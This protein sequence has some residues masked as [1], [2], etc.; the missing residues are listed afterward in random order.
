VTGVQTCALPISERTPLHVEGPARELFRTL[1]R[2][3][4]RAAHVHPR[5]LAHAGIDERCRPPGC[6]GEPGA[7]DGMGGGERFDGALEPQAVHRAT[8]AR[9]DGDVV[10][11]AWLEAIARPSLRL[12]KRQLRQAGAGERMHAKAVSRMDAR[13][14]RSQTGADVRRWD[15]M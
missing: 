15:G 4:P 13:G 14:Q 10:M 5:K 7:K 11:A 12:P 3:A 8:A 2:I 1:H 6:P 9:R